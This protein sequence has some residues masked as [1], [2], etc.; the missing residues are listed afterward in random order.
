MQH[1][2]QTPT[3]VA[4]TTLKQLS[5]EL[6]SN[7]QVMKLLDISERTLQTL[8]SNG[9]LPHIK[10][11]RICYYHLSDIQLMLMRNRRGGNYG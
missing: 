3:T 1:A 7:V 5:E 9:T 6:L 8:R 10:V 2:D 11:G 4:P